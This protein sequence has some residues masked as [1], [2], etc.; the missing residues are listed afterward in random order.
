MMNKL[1]LGIVVLLIAVGCNFQHHGASPELVGITPVDGAAGIAVSTGITISFS[2]SMDTQTCEERFGLYEG[3]LDA[4]PESGLPPLGGSFSWNADYTE[5][6]FD[7]AVPL[8]A[9]TAYSIVLREGMQEE[10]HHDNMMMDHDHDGGMMSHDMDGF[11]RIAGAG[12]II[13]FNTL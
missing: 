8:Q 10:H 6:T 13:I 1:L 5:M 11:G 4:L 2:E 7:P 12:I 9:S 3:A